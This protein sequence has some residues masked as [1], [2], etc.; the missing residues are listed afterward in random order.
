MMPGYRYTDAQVRADPDLFVTLALAYLQDYT[1]EFD[2]LRS[3]QVRLQNGHELT[4]PM[5]RAVLNCMRF[6]ASVPNMPEPQQREARVIDFVSKAERKRKPAQA[7]PRPAFID[8]PTRWK[9][10]YGI[11]HWVTAR[12]VHVVHPESVIRYYPHTG[13]FDCRLHWWC[14]TPW[15]MANLSIIELLSDE[16]AKHVLTV[17]RWNLC[18]T[19]AIRAELKDE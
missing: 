3:Y 12:S 14:K 11:S 13:E 15:S 19:C 6:D 2:L 1:G 9:M 8:L 16:E 17:P 18:G 5:I 4:V 7:S 10:R